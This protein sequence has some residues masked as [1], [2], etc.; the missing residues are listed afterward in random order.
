VQPDPKLGQI[1]GCFYRYIPE[2]FRPNDGSD[3]DDFGRHDDR[4]RHGSRRRRPRRLSETTGKLQ[5]LKLRDEFHADMENGR[6]VGEPYRVEWVD[7]P[8]PDHDDDTDNR[9]D[10]VPG[11]IPTR[12]QAQDQGAAWFEKMEGIW[13]DDSRGGD[14]DDD[15]ERAR[16]VFF[17]C[18][19]GGP[20]NKGSVWEYDPRR[21]TLTM[22]YESTDAAHLENPD[23]VVI[24][25]QTGDIFVQEDGPDTE[26]FVRGVTQDGEIY[27]FCR[28][29]SNTTEF[30]GGCFD[31]DGHTLYVNQQGERGE[32]PDGPAGAFGVMYAIYGPFGKARGRGRD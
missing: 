9:T 12:I 5:A 13:A 19:D 14:D 6:V 1:G 26:H 32:T 17:A 24:V 28:S 25:P 2:D 8:D 10:R 20:I 16:K 11:F 15:D 23:N 31:P 7:V 4:D 22:I 21:E 29:L 18:S 30:C 3:D 27:D